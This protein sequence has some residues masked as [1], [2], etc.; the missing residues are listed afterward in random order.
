MYLLLSLLISLVLTLLLELGFAWFWGVRGKGL[1][2]VI[3]MNIL[4][5][6]AVVTIHFLCTV[7]LGWNELF[8]VLLLEAAAI[9]AEGFCCRGMIRKP[10]TFSI[11][12]NLFSYLT[13]EL[14]QF[15]F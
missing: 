11:Y 6:P 8:P 9:T 12:V 4:T 2:L 15:L 14:L 1:A 5:N 10:W 7:V 13:G 3:L